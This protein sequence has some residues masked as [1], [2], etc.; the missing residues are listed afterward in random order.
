MTDYRAPLDDMQFVIREIADLPA[1]QALP[2]W[3]EVSNDLIDA[4]LEEAGR[5]ATEV[6]APLNMPGDRQGCDFE[7]GVVRVPDGFADA[8]RQF[9]DRGWNGL[10]L[11]NEHGGQE[12]PCLLSTAVG[13]MWSGANMSF[14]LCP[15][16]TQAAAELL[17]RHG[18]VRNSDGIPAE[19][20]FRRVDGYDAAD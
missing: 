13:E 12:L 16:L 10:A 1:M 14:A 4:V 3:E 2:G 5:F 7:N 17:A 9:V 8:W 18:D 6:L 20:R 11:P 15:I 19:T